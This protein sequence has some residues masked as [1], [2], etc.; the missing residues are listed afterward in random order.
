MKKRFGLA[1]AFLAAIAL[2][3]SGCGVDEVTPPVTA[4]ITGT[5]TTVQVVLGAGSIPNS[6]TTS[7]TATVT[8]SSARVVPNVNV[9]FSVVSA[10][11]G[12]FTPASAVTNASGVATSTFTANAGVDSTAFIRATVTLGTG[13][14]TGSASI[15]I[16]TPPRVPTS[17]TVALGSS[18][19]DNPGGPADNTTV[20]ATVSDAT[21]PIPNYTVLFSSSVAGAVNFT[22]AATATTNALGQ[23]TVTITAAL[24]DTLTDIT[25]TAGT[26]N[27]SASLTI[28]NP[29]GPAPTSMTLTASPLQI[30]IT[31]QSTITVTL[32]AAGGAPSYNRTVNLTISTNPGLGSFSSGSDL[33]ATT[34][35]TNSS[36]IASATFYSGA[37][38]GTITITATSGG[39][40][41]QVSINITSDPASI[42][43]TAAN[44]N[45]M[46]GQ[47][48][49]ITAD[50][51]NILNNAVSD[52]TTVTFAITAGA[53]G[54]G[55]LSSGTATTVNG[56]ASVTFTA[57]ASNTGSLIVTASAGTSPVVSA[58]VLITVSAAS[59]QSIEFVSAD[60]DVIGI[61]GSG[62][63][64]SSVVTFLVKDTNGNGLAG[65]QVDF[66][67]YGPTG[68]TLSAPTASTNSS[69]EAFTILQAGLVAGPARIV[70]SVTVNPGPPPVTISTSS[71]NI[72]IGGGVP[73]DRFF[74][75]SVTKFNLD[76]L[77]C[78]GVT[79]TLTAWIADRFGNYNILEGT[80]VSFTTDSGAVD[81]S[82]VTGPDG[83]TTS[84][85]RTQ[86][87]RPTDV[88]PAAWEPS[89]E[90]G[91]EPYTDTNGNC[92]WDTGEPYTDSN[93][94][95]SRDAG[96]IRNP[97]D[98]W[99]TVLVTTTG[100]EHFVDADADGVYDTGETFTDLKEPFI[101]SNDNGGR[102]SGELFFDWPAGVTGNTTGS[103]D[104]VNTV[105]DSRIPIYRNVN[106][107]FTG[108]PTTAFSG[109]SYCGSMIV[110]STGGIG[111]VTIPSGG[112]DYFYVYAS[113][114]NLNAPI[115]DTS[116]STSA[117]ATE[118]S[119][120]IAGGSGTV[121][122]HLSTGPWVAVYRMTNNNSGTAPVKT[123]FEATISWT[124]TCASQDLTI[125]YPETITL[126][127]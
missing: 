105:W 15:T 121:V 48:T 24:S 7:V 54:A 6:G 114:V 52:G 40:T 26:V 94:N 112:S 117:S 38:S 3:T 31:S 111:A 46:N 12:S 11:A 71:G 18:T 124:G 33:D 62:T 82:N 99:A 64:S 43:V 97:R 2:L 109:G 60:P 84:V 123:S 120:S 39:L 44:P 81:T 25:A 107:V 77:D 95:G 100:E 93:L 37:S 87:P 17:V 59:P 58:T 49:N 16:G 79:S 110:N 35:T 127:N 78:N 106:L 86:A 92:V 108:P 119:I 83:T 85:F 5:P 55:A 69:G 101:D 113:D 96:T 53:M 9:S 36:G 104:G 34:V 42:S 28:G 50:V 115:G 68:A 10:S 88:A 66:T 14:I 61:S 45:L 65:V 126:L 76:G 27:N 30:N 122:D 91:G 57:D 22:P 13:T 118:A 20:T 125:S 47:T 90:S 63:T 8:D 72:S 56:I 41:Q 73:S 23:A 51:R 103:H 80:S 75:V 19:I 1:A 70:A 102:D 116:I 4:V 32:L 74:D 21:G 29:I 98:G 67:L 89:W